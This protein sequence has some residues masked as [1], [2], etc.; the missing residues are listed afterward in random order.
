MLMCGLT[1]GCVDGGKA[2]MHIW[3]EVTLRRRG[4]N[5]EGS[6]LRSKRL[7]CRGIVHGIYMAGLCISPLVHS[8]T[9]SE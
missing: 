2:W 3:D 1:C 5:V 9:C 8:D 4:T 7:M 6:S